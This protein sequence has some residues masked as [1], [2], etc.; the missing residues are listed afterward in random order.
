MDKVG[1][2]AGVGAELDPEAIRCALWLVLGRN[3]TLSR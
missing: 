3:W 1:S 2:E